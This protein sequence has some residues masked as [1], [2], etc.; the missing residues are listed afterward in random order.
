M[1]APA[2]PPAPAPMKARSKTERVFRRERDFEDFSRLLEMGF[3]WFSIWASK[4]IEV[5]AKL[6]FVMPNLKVGELGLFKTG[7][8]LGETMVEGFSQF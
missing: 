4:G 6:R 5:E 2:I 3:S 8:F 7:D 1:N